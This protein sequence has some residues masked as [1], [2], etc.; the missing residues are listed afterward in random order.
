MTAL[1]ALGVTFSLHSSLT[2]VLG[3]IAI[4]A[5]LAAVF[6]REVLRMAL[7]L[8]VLL[9]TVAGIFLLYLAVLP[10][11]AEVFLY[12]GGVLVL[13]LFTLMLLRRDTAGTPQLPSRHRVSAAL[14][15]V[16]MFVVITAGF[17]P[18]GAAAPGSTVPIAR[19]AD[20]LLGSHLS[21][22]EMVAVL[23]LVAL[24][25]AVALSAGRGPAPSGAADVGVAQP[26]GEGAD[27]ALGRAA[28][29]AHA[30]TDAADEGSAS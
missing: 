28:G 2:L 13:L 24:V 11:V 26:I 27:G 6:S 3:V 4:L 5:A 19:I 18:M 22:F 1:Q 21:V 25:A 16:A 23:L 29:A 7:G 12:V 30:A 15:A 9:M 17:M 14:T 8:G 20:A 10:A